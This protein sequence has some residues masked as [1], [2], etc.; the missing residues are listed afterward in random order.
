MRMAWH[1]SPAWKH[2]R[3][4][5]TASS[6]IL[7][8]TTSSGR[9]GKTTSTFPTPRTLYEC[10]SILANFFLEEARKNNHSFAS[11]QEELDALIYN[12]PVT[13]T[14]NKTPFAQMYIFTS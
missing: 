13:F 11:A 9:N 8:R 5:S 1:L 2:T 4:L 3:T 10:R 6:S 12:Y 7:R 14:Q